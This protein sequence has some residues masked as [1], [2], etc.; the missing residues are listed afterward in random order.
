[1]GNGGQRVRR[2]LQEVRALLVGRK[3]L[4][5]KLHNVELSMRG[6]GLKVGKVSKGRFA[7]R[8]QELIVRIR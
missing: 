6:F 5:V 8:V 2:R 7:A 3:L 1:M 4:L